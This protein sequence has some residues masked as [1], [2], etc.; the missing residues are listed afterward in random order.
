MKVIVVE[1]HGLMKGRPVNLPHLFFSADKIIYEL[2]I[3][4]IRKI[5]KYLIAKKF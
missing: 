1:K 3:N 2:Y 5:V 4:F